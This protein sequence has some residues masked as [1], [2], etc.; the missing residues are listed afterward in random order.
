VQV[1]GAGG[2][3]EL[4]CLMILVDYILHFSLGGFEAVDILALACRIID[5]CKT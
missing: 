3:W 1:Q 5:R 2:G 4:P